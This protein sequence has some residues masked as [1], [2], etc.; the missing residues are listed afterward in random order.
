MKISK[1]VYMLSGVQHGT[2]SNSYVINTGKGL[3]L[4]DAGFTDYQFEVMNKSLRFW[5]LNHLPITH[6]FITHGHFDHAGN[7]HLAKGV[8]SKILAGPSDADG[9]ELGDKRTI[10]YMF[11][12]EFTPCKVDTV[13]VDNQ[14]IDIDGIEITSLHMPG[15]SAGSMM[16]MFNSDNYNM[17]VTGDFIA[18]SPAGP[19]DDVVVNLA[20]T[21]GPD[22]SNEDYKESIKKSLSLDVHILLPGHGPVYYGDCKRVF[23]MAFDKAKEE[24]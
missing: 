22:Y 14:K 20:W 15:H 10:G 16:F 6:T 2:N 21:G 18:L 17:L 1:N 13:L 19:V 5:G 3:I 8:G 12:K 11:K 4:F 24:L 23:Q 7:C 9:I